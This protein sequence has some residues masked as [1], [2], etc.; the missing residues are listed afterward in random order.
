M[1]LLKIISCPHSVFLDLSCPSNSEYHLFSNPKSNVCMEP[2]SPLAMIGREDCLCKHGFFRSVGK[3]V[4]KSECG[5]TYNGIYY[6]I[7]DNF[8]PDEQCQVHCV[9]VGHGEVQCTNSTCPRGTAC[10]IKDGHRECHP[11]QT[12]FKCTLIGGR[13]LR[14]YNGHNFD[15]HM[16]SCR[17]ALFQVC[18][19]DPSET[20]VHIQ[21][22]QLYLRMYGMNMTLE[23]KQWGKIKVSFKFL[24]NSKLN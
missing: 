18:D 9:C 12:A 20:F 24:I 21:Q 10:G 14:T 2:P 6:Q 3:C 5:C 7:H 1:K 13:H 8:Y 4:P 15:F 22:G 16:G 17:Y 19:E 11:S 23:M